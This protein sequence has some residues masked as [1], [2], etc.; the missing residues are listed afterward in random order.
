[1]K[2]FALVI[3]MLAIVASACAAANEELAE[4]IIERSGG[5]E[6]DVD[7][8]LDTGQVSVET[9]EGSFSVGGGE[10]PDGFPV[11]FPDGGSVQS[12]F[13]SDTAAS[14]SL[15]YPKD[16]F[17]ELVAYYEA[18]TADQGGEWSTSSFTND[19]G[20]GGVIRGHSW[21][22][23]ADVNLGVTDCFTLDGEGDNTNATCVSANVQE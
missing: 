13:T 20:S 17:D 5:G 10:I 6:A 22:Q 12:V 8:D 3:A 1:M 9:E 23:G 21:W 19:D 16:R 7:L 11:P 4:Q 14:V 18:W 15:A 2:R